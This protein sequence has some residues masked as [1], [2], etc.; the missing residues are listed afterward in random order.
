MPLEKYPKCDLVYG[1]NDL[2][3][4]IHRNGRIALSPGLAKAIAER[5]HSTS[6]NEK[7]RIGVI[8]HFDK[9]TGDIGLEPSPPESQEAFKVY[10][11]MPG[12]SV[13]Y[14]VHAK[15]FLDR[16]DIDYKS[17]TRRFATWDEKRGLFMARHAS[18]G[19]MKHVRGREPKPA[20]ASLALDDA[21]KSAPPRHAEVDREVLGSKTTRAEPDPLI[22][23]QD[24]QEFEE[25]PD[26]ARKEVLRW[27][28]A[29]HYLGKHGTGGECVRFAASITGA[30]ASTVRRKFLH[31]NRANKDWRALIDR[32]KH[33]L[34]AG[35]LPKDF[36]RFWRG[37]CQINNGNCRPAHAQLIAIWKQGVLIPGYTESPEAQPG[38]D[39]P[40]GW[41]Y[42][43]LTAHLLTYQRQHRSRTGDQ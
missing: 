14:T 19:E 25:L 17:G 42:S 40:C 32:A 15:A 8:L 1:P 35:V 13:A 6:Q 29:V 9:E 43:N 16:C 26:E 11:R 30:G 2:W 31:Y 22:P 7:P 10:I 3:V 23:T 24:R 5:L 38:K 12:G 33:P 41:G 4:T 36:K 39:F 34:N 21:V 28:H 37:L 27:L 18:A 20:A